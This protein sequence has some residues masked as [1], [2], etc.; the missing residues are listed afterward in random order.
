M[1]LSLPSLL[2]DMSY[3][4]DL[5]SFIFLTITCLYKLNPSIGKIELVNGYHLFKKIVQ[6]HL[7]VQQ[8]IKVYLFYIVLVN[9]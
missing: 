3:S 4:S 2:A 5:D 9:I 1:C 7:F 8:I 6:C